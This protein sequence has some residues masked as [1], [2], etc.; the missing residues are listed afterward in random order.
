[1][2]IF[3]NVSSVCEIS[4]SF[5][6]ASPSNFRMQGSFIH[7][8]SKKLFERDLLLS[9]S[10]ANLQRKNLGFSE[11]ELRPAQ[12]RKHC[13]RN[14]LCQCCSQCCMGEQTGKKQNISCFQDANSA[15]SRYVALVR[16]RG[17]I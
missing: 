5:E 3:A 13:C 1:M 15:S 14:I 12:T 6:R 7:M 10:V 9:D 2:K 4:S 16:K 8:N 17:N 11:T